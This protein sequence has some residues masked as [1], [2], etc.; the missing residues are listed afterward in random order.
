MERS[1]SRV[2]IEPGLRHSTVWLCLH[3]D[4]VSKWDLWPQL[5]FEFSIQLLDLSMGGKER[6]KEAKLPSWQMRGEEISRI[7]DDVICFFIPLS[8]LGDIKLRRLAKSQPE[9]RMKFWARGGGGGGGGE[10]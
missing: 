1:I 10:R 8:T 5:L 6:E 2:R 3:F 4:K 7:A 9:R